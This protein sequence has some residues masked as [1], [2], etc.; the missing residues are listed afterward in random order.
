M[1]RILI[2]CS[3]L[4]AATLAAG[5]TAQN[6]TGSDLPAIGSAG[7]SVISRD[8]EYQLGRMVVAGLRDQGQILDDPEINDYIQNLGSRIAA[9][10]QESPQRFQ[11][12]V[13]RDARIKLD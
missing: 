5:V 6:R 11:F 1:R 13:V 3:A 4:L 12:F 7:D 8:E 2:A 9:Q 10:A